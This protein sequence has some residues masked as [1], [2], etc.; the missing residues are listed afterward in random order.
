MNRCTI[1]GHRGLYGPDPNIVGGHTPVVIDHCV[2]CHKILRA[3]VLIR[4]KYMVFKK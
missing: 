4:G 3:F 2:D 1:I